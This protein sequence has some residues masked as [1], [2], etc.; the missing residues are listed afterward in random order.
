MSIEVP[1]FRLPVVPRYL[2]SHGSLVQAWYWRSMG[3]VTFSAAWE[4][5]M[6]MLVLKIRGNYVPQCSMG[7]LV[8]EI[9][10]NCDL[11]CS[12]EVQDA[13]AGT[14]D[15]WELCPSVQHGS[16][17]LP[18]HHQGVQEV[19]SCSYSTIYEFGFPT[20]VSTL[21]MAHNPKRNIRIET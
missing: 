11:Q 1:G 9:R 20:L 13:H 6:P 12:M 8:L 16:P 14:E 10:G 2:S 21:G 4:S 3:I 5:R 17:G 7:V 15:P 18:Y 19:H